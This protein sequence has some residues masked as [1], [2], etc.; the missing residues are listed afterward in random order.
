MPTGVVIGWTLGK[1]DHNIRAD[2]GSGDLF[3]VPKDIEG[4][5]PLAVW[6]RVEFEATI[7]TLTGRP[8]ARRVRC[9]AR[10]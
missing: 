7:D 6:Q 3:A 2:D 10:E 4:D 8:R 1:G 5:L 9:I